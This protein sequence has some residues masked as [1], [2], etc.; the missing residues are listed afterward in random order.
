M[1]PLGSWA[2]W[3]HGSP[4]AHGFPRANGPQRP[5]GPLRLTGHQRPMGPMWPCLPWAYGAGASGNPWALGDTW[6]HA[7]SEAPGHGPRFIFNT[8]FMF[9]FFSFLISRTIFDE[10]RKRIENISK[11][12]NQGLEPLPPGRRRSW[13]QKKIKNRSKNG[14]Q[15]VYQGN[16]FPSNCKNGFTSLCKSCPV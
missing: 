16:P 11:S 2:P 14:D 8:S 12:R 1:G 13:D 3:P 4:R 9:L 10:N 15:D 7:S 6:A 5:T